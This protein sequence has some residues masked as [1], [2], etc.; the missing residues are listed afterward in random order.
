MTQIYVYKGKEVY[1]TGR[2]AVKQGRRTSKTLL[3]IRLKEYINR[4]MDDPNISSDWV[5]EKDLYQ[6]IEQENNN[7]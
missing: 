3:E 1:L 2:T 7:D 5:E 4:D 6:I